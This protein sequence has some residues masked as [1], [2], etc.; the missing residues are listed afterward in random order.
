MKPRQIARPELSDARKL[1]PME[2]NG[3]K[4]ND[5]HTLLTPEVLKAMAIKKQN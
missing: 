5:R 1:T 3:L 4:F 2:M